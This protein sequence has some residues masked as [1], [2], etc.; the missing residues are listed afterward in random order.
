MFTSV[1][2]DTIVFWYSLPQT[3]SAFALPT[4]HGFP[5]EEYRK[6]NK[7]ALP[8]RGG[9]DTGEITRFMMKNIL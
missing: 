6:C 8:H 3:F 2:C 1:I 5:F 7:S 9:A 4:F